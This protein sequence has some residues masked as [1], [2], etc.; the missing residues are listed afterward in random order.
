M[1]PPNWGSE[2]PDKT[3]ILWKL[4]SLYSIRRGLTTFMPAQP[5]SQP[6]SHVAYA[7]ALA[8][9]LLSH[10]AS[11][12]ASASP[13]PAQ[14]IGEQTTVSI[15][16]RSASVDELLQQLDSR[17]YRDRE[18]ATDELIELG[19]QIFKPLATHYFEASSEAGW[20]IHR[21]LEGIGKNAQEQDFLKS[22][23][24]IQVLY[25][26][27]DDR[28]QHRLAQLQYQW[29]A[30]RREDAARQLRDLGFKFEAP[31]GSHFDQGAGMDL[32]IQQ[33]LR[34][35]VE[36]QELG[37][38]KIA[39]GANT[40]IKPTVPTVEWQDPRIDQRKSMLKLERIIAG[41]ADDNRGAVEG[42]LPEA[43]SVM[44]PPGTLEI[45]KGWKSD[46]Q[47]LKLINNLSTLS[48]LTLRQQKIDSGLQE[49]IV[50][51]TKLKNLILVDCDFSKTTDQF[52]LPKSIYRYEFEGSLPPA[53]AFASLGTISSLKLRRI[54]LTD[55]IAT[56]LSRGE[57]KLIDLEE[58]RFTRD[59]IRKLISMQGLLRVSVSLCPLKLAWLEDIRRN[60]PSLVVAEPK[61]FLG[62]QGTVEI[63]GREFSGCQISQ[64]V[65]GTAAAEAGMESL[66]VVTSMDGEVVRRFEDLRLLISQK[67]PGDTMKFEV[68]RDNKKVNL[69]IKLGSMAGVAPMP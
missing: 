18:M 13:L 64:V 21:I 56:A 16:S 52:S 34:R 43:Q 59:S 48:S 32:A 29:K 5:K 28:N 49:F 58:V 26:A 6:R 11:S 67:Q 62:V 1:P 47:S 57:I 53:E 38:I 63:T 36:I 66:D 44:L 61:A 35:R 46:K 23:A 27:Q 60:N 22:I 50:K 51:Q 17:S 15:E 19:P 9:L 41:D 3:H 25:G 33:A 2:D 8:M 65:P 10:F 12:I 31:Q 39:V 24:I 55:E 30:T 37:A 42:L 4:R 40:T 45:P 7:A 20:R 69:K 54:S 14:E 68:L